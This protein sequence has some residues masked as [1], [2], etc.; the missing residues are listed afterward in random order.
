MDVGAL[1]SEIT[2]FLAQSAGGA[3]A[4]DL[5]KDLLAAVR[6]RLTRRRRADR[7]GSADRSAVE[8]ALDRLLAA[9]AD[10][11]AQAAFTQALAGWLAED[12]PAAE[13]LRGRL[14][15]E[16][17]QPTSATPDVVRGP[18]GGPATDQTFRSSTEL[19]VD[20]LDR[21][22]RLGAEAGAD[23]VRTGFPDLDRLIVG[24]HPATLV[25][26]AGRPA[27]G[28][29]TFALDIVRHAAIRA[30][31]PAALV[32]FQA[33]GAE[34]VQRVI[35][36]EATIDLR[37]LLTAWLDEAE[38]ARLTRALGR[39]AQAPLAIAVDPLPDLA[40]LRAT[41][42]RHQREAGGLGLLVV[43]GLRELVGGH[44][45]A[46]SAGPE[47]TVR[48]TLQALKGLARELAVPVVVTTQ[49]RPG[50]VG[51]AD[52]H[53]TLEDLTEAEQQLA[54]LA[55]LLYRDDRLDQGSPRQGEAD[56]LVAKHRFGPTG[57]VTV[58]HQ[59]VFARFA[60][61]AASSR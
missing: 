6:H 57:V 1:A 10:Q 35:A 56:L 34:L 25:L 5:G 21:L 24:L 26:V 2:V 20:E 36:A 54:D 4:G 32:S 17:G 28:A 44:Q 46:A 48:R 50:E 15:A 22:D 41:C 11:D 47:A 53:P 29:S 49:L 12:P 30:G 51:R 23:G 33:A 3:V 27:A 13:A 61:M 52:V 60:P 14:Q 16:L 55:L 39:L 59:P 58:V 31:V 37:H 18:A 9:P 43:D 8:Q 38:W 40:A 45:T 7:A 19:L 42:Q